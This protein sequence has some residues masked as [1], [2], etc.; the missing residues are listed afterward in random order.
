MTTLK[1]TKRTPKFQFSSIIG[2]TK[3]VTYPF[4]CMFRKLPKF[5]N[6]SDGMAKSFSVE[7]K[8]Y[9]KSHF[10]NLKKFHRITFFQKL[11]SEL[12]HLVLHA[13]KK[14]GWVTEQNFEIKTNVSCKFYFRFSRFYAQID[15]RYFALAAFF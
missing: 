5:F 11:L 15:F 13:C 7:L 6:F 3:S 1:A 10:M 2:T 9:W 8:L 4:Y 12:A 14:S